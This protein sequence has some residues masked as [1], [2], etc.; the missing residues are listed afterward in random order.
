MSTAIFPSS[1]GGSGAVSSVVSQT[2]DVTAIQ[3]QAATV[4]TTST[5]LAA[6]DQG[7]A[8]AFGGTPTTVGKAVVLLTNPS[9][10]AF[11]R[12]NADNTVTALSA[13]NFRTAIGAGTGNGTGDMLKSDNLSGLANAGTALTN[14]GATSSG[15]L[16]LTTAN[17]SAIRYRR[18]NADNTVSDLTTAQVAVEVLGTALLNGNLIARR[19]ITGDLT[20][21]SADFPVQSVSGSAD[22]VVKLPASSGAAWSVLIQNVGA[23]LVTVKDSTAATTYRVLPAAS[24]TDVASVLVAWDGTSLLVS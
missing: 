18:I 22:W 11:P 12:I 7:A 10:I 14:L 15:A 23:Y 24:G 16:I 4:G 9:A 5:T 21:T 19:N 2:G 8:T 1:A 6:G 13:S 17:P 3:I 20:L